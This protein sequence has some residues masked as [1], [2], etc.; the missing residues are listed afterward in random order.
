MSTTLV[1]HQLLDEG[2]DPLV[3]AYVEMYLLAP[4]A[5][6]NAYVTGTNRQIIGRTVFR[7][8]SNGQW[9]LSMVP[10][11]EITPEGTVYEVVHKLIG[12]RNQRA[13]FT[14]PVS[15]DPVTVLDNLV[16]PPTELGGGEGSSSSIVGLY[17]PPARFQ[18][19]WDD[20]TEYAQ[21]EAVLL[22]SEL[23]IA[24]DAIAAGTLT[25]DE[26]H[27]QRIFDDDDPVVLSGVDVNPATF[28]AVTGT[29]AAGGFA[30][31]DLDDF[32]KVWVNQTGS[33]PDWQLQPFIGAGASSPVG[34]VTASAGGYY[35]QGAAG[36]FTKLWLGIGTTTGSWADLTSAT[37][38]G[39][40][41]PVN[42]VAASGVPAPPG[43]LFLAT[44][45]E[46]P[47]RAYV[48]TAANDLG[49]TVVPATAGELAFD[50]GDS[51]MESTNVNDAIIEAFLLNEGGGNLVGQTLNVH[52]Y[53]RVGSDTD[54]PAASGT[55][56]RFLIVHDFADGVI[57]GTNA[58]RI[59]GADGTTRVVVSLEDDEDVFG[60]PSGGTVVNIANKAGT[61]F[62]TFVQDPDSA[63]GGFAHG[64]VAVG[65]GHPGLIRMMVTGGASGGAQLYAM[66]FE[67]QTVP[68][69]TLVDQNGENLFRVAGDG[70]LALYGVAVGLDTDDRP[71]LTTAAVAN[72]VIANY[73]ALRTA[74]IA[75][76]L[77]VDGDLP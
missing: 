29:T 17:V 13:T 75:L 46:A 57:D 36:V 30:Y 23:Y 54:L 59:V 19:A 6:D 53:G 55:T 7:T 3:N 45:D 74:L 37:V 34:S 77:A 61:H 76:G 20:A 72:D 69:I 41:A 31:V 51:D 38:S 16:D 11:S 39:N 58:F 18:G 70:S 5:S 12:L 43:S 28:G 52:Q 63:G 48:K 64:Q 60:T 4:S 15:D 25:S 49:W 8:D 35:I 10:N 32:T 42:G 56:P 21:G 33:P 40:G 73:N 66:A 50:A 26:D 2:G 1:T 27:W 14:V 47:R 24:K 22:S 62:L 9:S 67:D 65:H 71:A 68:L 44:G